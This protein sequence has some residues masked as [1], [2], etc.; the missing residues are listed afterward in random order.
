MKPGSSVASPRSMMR[1]LAGMGPPT[2]VILLPST[3]MTAFRVTVSEVPSKSRAALMATGCA[4]AS[5]G[6]KKRA[7]T[8]FF[9]SVQYCI[10]IMLGDLI[11]R[12]PGIVGVAIIAGL[13]IL[14]IRSIFR[15]LQRWEIIPDPLFP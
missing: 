14:L 15:A 6:K 4:R 5:V 11:E 1:A 12:H 9:M 10:V 3:T 7:A 13:L 2:A 8:N